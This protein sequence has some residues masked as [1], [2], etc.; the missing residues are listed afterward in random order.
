MGLLRTILI[1][2]AIYFLFKL[3]VRILLPYILK[4]YIQKK[5]NEFQQRHQ[6]I[7]KKPEGEITIET[8]KGKDDKG[9][10]ADYEEIK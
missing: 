8:R 9:D 2:L 7:N 10:Y 6:D 3:V 5:Q 1:L 4:T